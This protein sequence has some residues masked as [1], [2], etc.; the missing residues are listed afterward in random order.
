MF[1]AVDD[2]YLVPFD[3]SFDIAAAA[4]DPPKGAPGRK[5]LA[6]ELEHAVQDL[7]DLQRRL[8]ANDEISVLTVFQGMDTAGKDGTIRAVFTG[9]N[10][11][12]VH[13]VPFGPPSR[14]DLD[15]DFLWRC[16]RHLPERGRIGVFNRSWYEEVLIARVHP[17]IVEAQRLPWR[18][19]GDALWDERLAS[20]RDLEQHLARNGTVILKFFLNLSR[21]E[22]RKRLE[23]R[24]D[25]PS[26]RW[27]FDPTDLRERT[28]WDDYA[29]AY[30]AAL[31]ATS[32]PWAP[33][34]AIPADDKRYMRATVARLL[35]HTMNELS[36][37]WPEA[38]PEQELKSLRE[39]LEQEER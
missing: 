16:V 21:K 20:I 23:A 10:P 17:K 30:Q 8:F 11:A 18:P 32:R 24:L 36:L 25:D 9:V 12:G 15:H 33:W 27:K 5:D 26:K 6:K 35:V 34:Y 37:P 31:R 7:Q 1:R 14:E 29:G 2:P 39:V 19:E 13:V 3:E 4:T 38:L 22:Q 28:L